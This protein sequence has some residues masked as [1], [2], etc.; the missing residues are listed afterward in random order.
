MQR[1]IEYD[2]RDVRA[3]RLRNNYRVYYQKAE[4]DKPRSDNPKKDAITETTKQLLGDLIPSTVKREYSFQIFESANNEDEHEYWI[5]LYLN[6]KKEKV[7]FGDIALYNFEPRDKAAEK[8]AYLTISDGLLALGLRN[9]LPL[10]LSDVEF[11]AA[12]RKLNTTLEKRK[13]D[14]LGKE[15]QAFIAAIETARAQ[16]EDLAIEDFFANRRLSKFTKV[17]VFL[18]EVAIDPKRAE[19]FLVPQLEKLPGRE[20]LLRRWLMSTA[21]AVTLIVLALSISGLFFTAVTIVAKAAIVALSGI[22]LVLGML[23]LLG[24]LLKSADYG[25]FKGA[26]GGRYDACAAVYE[27]IEKAK[28]PGVGV[29]PSTIRLTDTESTESENLKEQGDYHPSVV[30]QP[31]EKPSQPARQAITEE[32]VLQPTVKPVFK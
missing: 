31:S 22:G 29:S 23:S 28:V 2:M 7:H 3:K 24:L 4:E 25:G 11:L 26:F 13:K 15:T 18:N 6:N 12:D 20:S 10:T 8:P 17:L 30:S 1:R 32:I 9:K 5:S 27:V 14:D 19:E 16:I 21:T